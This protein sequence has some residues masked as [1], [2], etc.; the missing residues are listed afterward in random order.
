[1]TSR[2]ESFKTSRKDI[3]AQQAAKAKH[4]NAIQN[5]M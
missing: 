4:M 2:D 5:E 3:A 1:M